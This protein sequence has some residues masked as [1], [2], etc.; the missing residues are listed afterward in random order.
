MDPSEY[1]YVLPEERIRLRPPERREDS[2]LLRVPREGAGASRLGFFR[3]SDLPSLLA[4]GDR[5]VVNDSRVVPARVSGTCDR[6]RPVEVLFLGPFPESGSG[7]V[8]FLG[9]GFRPGSRIALF[10]GG[11]EIVVTGYSEADGCFSGEYRGDRPLRAALETDGEMPIPPYIAKRRKA[12]REDRE[13]YQTVFSRVD[14]S[15]AA[16]TAGLHL[17]EALLEALV[18]SG[19]GVSTVT[20][21]VGMGTFRPLPRE[22]IAGH[23]MHSEWYCV[24]PETAREIGRTREGGGRVVAVGTTS[25]RAL[26]SCARGGPDGGKK[27]VVAMSGW[28]DLFIR[29]G[30]RFGPVD[31]LLTNF[32]TPRSTLLVL[33]DAF[34]GGNRWREIYDE[35][36]RQEF[37]FLSYGDAMLIL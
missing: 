20:L 11:A 8:A 25:L 35:A 18:A 22:G 27:E 32:H 26:E 7:T 36:L 15:V 1:E 14:G 17:S 4:P 30:H 21:H 16:P 5:L 33:V 12:D 23:V 28:T 31:G 6:G 9:K 10:S 24:T 2:R 29:P 34:L 19:V 37:A 3:I 13:R